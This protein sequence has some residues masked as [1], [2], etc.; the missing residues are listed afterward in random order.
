[1]P[2]GTYLIFTPRK[3]LAEMDPN[4]TVASAVQAALGDGGPQK[5]QKLLADSVISTETSIYAFNPQLSYVSKEWMDADP[6]YWTL[7]AMPTPG[8][9][10]AKKTPAKAEEKKQ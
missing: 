6:G 5:R 1:M 7:K 3:S 10:P 9:A 8:P 4:P 2:S